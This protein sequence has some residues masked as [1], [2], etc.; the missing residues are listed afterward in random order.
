M[1]DPINMTDETGGAGDPY[2]VAPVDGSPPRPSARP[3]TDLVVREGPADDPYGLD[4]AKEWLLKREEADPGCLLR[5][6]M[7]AEVLIGLGL[8]QQMRAAAGP[9]RSGRGR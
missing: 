7:P 5:E 6:G 4:P 1:N 2:A 9:D 3:A 8:Y